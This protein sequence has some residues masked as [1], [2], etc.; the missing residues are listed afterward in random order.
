VKELL[1]VVAGIGLGVLVP[2]IIFWWVNPLLT[3]IGLVVIPAGAVI[4]ALMIRSFSL[5]VR[6][7]HIALV[8]VLGWPVA[9]FGPYAGR[10]YFLRF[11]VRKYAPEVP[12]TRR[13]R[14]EV[15]IWTGQDG[16]TEVHWLLESTLPPQALRDSYA[17]ALGLDR[18]LWQPCGAEQWCLVFKVA[19]NRVTLWVPWREQAAFHNDARTMIK[20]L[21]W[22]KLWPKLLYPERKAA[23]EVPF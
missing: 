8:V 6:W 11:Q 5:R 10:H 3:V 9:A 21:F 15:K 14:E 4:G 20:L 13:I 16:S 23:T 7:W 12:D 17:D 2:S 18:D 19:G 1:G 22:P